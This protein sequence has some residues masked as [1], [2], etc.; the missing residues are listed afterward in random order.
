MFDKFVKKYKK[1]R[2]GQEPPNLNDDF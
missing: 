2:F 1:G